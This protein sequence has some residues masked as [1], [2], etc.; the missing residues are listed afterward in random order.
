MLWLLAFHIISVICWYAGLFYLPRLYVYHTT[1]DDELGIERFKVMERRLYYAIMWPAALL[2]TLFGVWMLILGWTYFSQALWM[3]AK[4]FCVVLLWIFH[5]YCG[6]L[7]KYFYENKNPHSERF[8]RI[9]NEVPTVLL[10][11]IVIFAIVKPF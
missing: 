9:I 2:S 4:L 8:Y 5:L 11:A 3:H 1:T 7:R 6:R 10:F